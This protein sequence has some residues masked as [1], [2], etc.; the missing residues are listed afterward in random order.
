MMVMKKCEVIKIEKY[1]AE[2]KDLE[3]EKMMADLVKEM[4]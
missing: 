4:K 1:E 3:T 2:K